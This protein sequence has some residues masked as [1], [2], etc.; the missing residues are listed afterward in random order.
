MPSEW[1]WHRC[2]VL[3][4]GK[5]VWG[6]GRGHGGWGAGGGGGKALVA[7]ER[8]MLHYNRGARACAVAE[9]C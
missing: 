7:P 3:D 4:G 2:A 1:G 5:G 8:R 6:R 9:E